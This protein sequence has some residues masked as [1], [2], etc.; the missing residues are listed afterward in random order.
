M[1]KSTYLKRIKNLDHKFLMGELTQKQYA[2]KRNKLSKQ[3]VK[4]QMAKPT[5][6]KRGSYVY[7]FA[8]GTRKRTARDAAASFSIK[9]RQTFGRTTYWPSLWKWLKKKGIKR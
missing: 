3:W 9:K 2:A 6:V 8:P 1:K 4:S 7:L 5:I